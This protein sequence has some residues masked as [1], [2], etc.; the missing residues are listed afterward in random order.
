MVATT[1]YA[2]NITT[3][4]NGQGALVN[5]RTHRGRRRAIFDTHAKVTGDGDDSVMHILRLKTTDVPISLIRYNDALS[6]A[7]DVDIGIYAPLRDGG[8]VY[9]A[10]CFADGI[11]L[12]SASVV[13]V[14]QR[15]TSADINGCKKMMWELAGLTAD[16]GGEM[17]ICLTLNTAGSA[18]GDITLVA[19]I[20]DGS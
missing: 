18:A 14:Q 1:T 8:A 10:D 2:P 13:G 20:L 4:D 3:L 7:T 15:F 12:A 9:S 6:G 16:P 17:D 11:S 5:G 19:E